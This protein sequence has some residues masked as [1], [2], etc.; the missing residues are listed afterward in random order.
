MGKVKYTLEFIFFYFLI[1]IFIY[2]FYLFTYLFFLY[3]YLYG[4]GLYVLP[5]PKCYTR[6]IEGGAVDPQH[7][8]SRGR[9]YE[10]GEGMPAIPK[11]KSKACQT[12][13]EVEIV[14]V[15]DSVSYKCVLVYL[16][17]SPVCEK[18]TCYLG[19]SVGP[20]SQVE[21]Q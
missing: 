3:T 1:S 2:L 9:K 4:L 21:W 7:A 17:C 12:P 10:E 19:K 8:G 20:N 14:E 13:H 15:T 16:Y 5:S 6:Q 18:C 11:E